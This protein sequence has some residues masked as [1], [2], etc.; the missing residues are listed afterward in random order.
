VTEGTS[1]PDRPAEG[2]G[3]DEVGADRA[4]ASV[5]GPLSLAVGHA[6]AGGDALARHEEGE[7]ILAYQ[8]ALPL[9]EAAVAA[10][11][12]P[13][14][15]LV[16]FLV[17]VHDV[18]G[19]LMLGRSHLDRAEQ[20]YTAGLELSAARDH[21]GTDVAKF[22]NNLGSVARNRGDLGT[23][24]RLYRRAAKLAGQTDPAPDAVATYLS[25]TGTI[26]LAMGD[27][28]GALGLFRRALEIDERV[29]PGAA[30]TDLSLI[31]SVLV[32]Y[33]DLGRAMDHHQRALEVH[34]A[35]DPASSEMA[36]DL[37]NVG[38]CHR[39]SGDLD[40]ALRHYYAALDI[41]RAL[42][43]SSLQTATDLNNISRVYRLRGDVDRARHY[44]EQALEISRAAAPRSQRT[45]AQ[46]T[47]LGA[48]YAE[49]GQHAAA[50]A[51]FL[52]AL[53]I[54]NAVAPRSL[55]TARD[56]NNLASVAI[57]L[58]DLEQADNYCHQALEIYR[59]VVPDSESIAV[60][61]TTLAAV[62]HARG[63]R[64][65]ALTQARAAL[66]IDQR[67]VPDAEP[68]ITD[69]VN[70]A[71]LHAEGGELD[72]A[73]IR[74]AEAVDIA[75]SLR[76]R[77]GTA[78]AREERF[79]LH[80]SPY[81]G[82]VRGL[83]RRG[84]GD[85][86]ERAFDVAERSRGRALA[87]LLT[88][89]R[90]DIR[91][92]NEVQ[93]SLLAEE[94]RLEDELAAINRRLAASVTAEPADGV[95]V[96]G[97]VTM[98]AAH[99]TLLSRRHLAGEHLERLRL[100]IRS[101]F[102]AYADLR[103]PEP[104]GLVAVQQMLHDSTLLLCY[105][106]GDRGCAMWAVR[107]TDWHA[108][109]LTTGQ[110]ALSRDI[111]AALAPCRS[112]E[113]ETPEAAAAWRRLGELLLSPV[114]S[115]W[116][117]T[118]AQVVVIGDGP[119]WYLPFDLL[120]R[121]GGRLADTL[122]VSYVPSVTVLGDLTERVAHGRESRPGRT[123]LGIGLTDTGLS[124]DLLP[125]PGARE[126]SEIA[127]DYGPGAKAVTGTEATKDVI[128]REAAGYRV[129]HFATHGVIDDLN[130]LYSGLQ[131]ALG[132]P[133]RLQ[134]SNGPELLHVYEMFALDLAAAVVV[135]SACETARG[136]IRSGEGLVGMSRALFYAGATAL[137]VSLWPV[138]DTPTRRLMR[139]FHRHLRSGHDP[140][141]ALSLAKRDVRTS[142]PHVYRHPYTWAGFI[143]LGTA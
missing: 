80:Q 102:P 83:L 58:G 21:G 90:L 25:N 49:A 9:A 108:A 78:E 128:F 116:L 1:S 17:Y 15:D 75:E 118:A 50:R 43:P 81:Q 40:Q 138:P 94:K 41:D 109:E 101:Q 139:V 88:R 68:T 99:D 134:D 82:L 112:A 143:V 4:G 31:G 36:R 66:E 132:E 79:A 87:D 140:A 44:L 28:A 53:D 24:L 55:E 121:G 69:L 19:G 26:L 77:A 35:L 70:L 38:Y 2:A 86:A 8:R 89:R 136:T 23:A 10:G 65:T 123:F 56:L 13:H 37:V 59:A 107:R 11:D 129:V 130:P 52:E 137:V 64:D 93:R 96:S 74:Y 104:L 119:V 103:D 111:D 32:E 76:R 92:D 120:P 85:D 39:L 61:Y 20:H 135:C 6:T 84:H 48:I 133:A 105:H 60:V 126:V 115:G 114:P 16:R 3:A 33:G 5:A 97:P 18:L 124:G 141:R 27:L 12:G 67:Q 46:L 91:P 113:P 98:T 51:V 54:D 100:T 72:E 22:T 62:A 110:A 14:E 122:V 131:V 142:H 117:T 57:N 47:G 73:I 29:D 125:L 63:D 34:R 127:E 45:A 71:V 42:G 106:I 7:A 30:A 95:S